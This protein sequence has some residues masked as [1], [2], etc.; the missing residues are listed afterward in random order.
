M[1][2]AGKGFV[3]G[4]EVLGDG[5]R[6]VHQLIFSSKEGA[7]GIE[8]VE[9]VAEALGVE[10]VRNFQRAAIGAT[11]SFN[12]WQRKHWTFN[13]PKAGFSHVQFLDATLAD[14]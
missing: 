4:N 14:A 10:F 5:A 9:E 2:S 11:G 8:H 1:P 3:E 6:A 7:F 13:S 12:A